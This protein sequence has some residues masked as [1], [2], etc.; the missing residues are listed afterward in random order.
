MLQQSGFSL[1]I[2]RRFAVNRLPYVETIVDT[3]KH[4]SWF[5]SALTIGR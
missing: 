3:W 5:G 4:H 2:R 1:R